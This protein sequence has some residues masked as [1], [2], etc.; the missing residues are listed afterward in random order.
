MVASGQADAVLPKAAITDNP[1]RVRPR[2][3]VNRGVSCNLLNIKS[4]IPRSTRC[5][6]A[7]GVENDIVP[8]ATINGVSPA[9]PL[10][11]VVAFTTDKNIA[12]TPPC[13]D[14]VPC[15]AIEIIETVA[16]RDGIIA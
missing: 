12:T 16:T 5:A 15:A 2:T 11:D 3:A 6:A 13:E 8:C 10:D 14:V 9:S 4:V 7:I 1:S